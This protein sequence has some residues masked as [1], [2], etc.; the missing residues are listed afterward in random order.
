M[1]KAPTSRHSKPSGKNASSEYAT[2]ENALKTVLSVPHS[3]LQSKIRAQ[4]R[5]K[6]KS[7]SASHAVNGQD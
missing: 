7:S 2:F 1:E 6:A 4:K 5:K 3:K